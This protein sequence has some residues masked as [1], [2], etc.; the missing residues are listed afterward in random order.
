MVEPLQPLAGRRI[1]LG[2][3]G[4]IA[5][6]KAAEL[7]RDLQR[8]GALL[9]VAMTASAQRFITALT[10]EAITHRPVIADLWSMPS[11]EISHVERAHEV[12]AMVIAPASANVIARLAAGMADDPVTAIALSTRAPLL[13]A[14]AM[15]SGMWL[16]PATQENVARLVSR[17]VRI[18]APDAGALASGREGVGRL[19]ELSAILLGVEQLFVSGGAFHGRRVLITAGPTL[20][21]LD[22]V[23]V[24]SNRSTGAMGIALA[25]TAARRGAEVTLILGPTHLVPP[26]GVTT[27]RV[28]S[29]AE[30][31]EAAGAV[32]DQTDVLIGAA[33]V[34]DYR[35]AHA[36]TAKL[37][38][39]DP[40]AKVIELVENPDLL[41]TLSARLRQRDPRAVV[42]GFAA[43]TEAVEENARLKLQKKGCDLVIGNR[44]GPDAGF[45]PGYTE[46]IAVRP[47][48]PPVAF[49]PA[50]K[51]RIAEFVLDRVALIAK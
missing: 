1:L 30:M 8:A 11:H 37:K 36:V 23:R 14:P 10:F 35:P 9:Q 39:S 31:L 2:V 42:V 19:A 45:G 51:A 12:D 41:A 33:A 43:E 27:I 7:V 29:A 38:R 25:G 5:A 20:E 18:V 21:K 44:V 13:V 3:S 6:Y 26:P 49:G 22:P 24:L 40:R 50:P 16:N 17:G 47:G 15:E 34:S 46:V 28:E 4:S 32:I 48:E